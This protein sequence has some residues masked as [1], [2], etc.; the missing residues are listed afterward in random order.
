MR[1]G[2][3]LNHNPLSHQ[4]WSIDTCKGNNFQEAF[5]QSKGL[6]LSSTLF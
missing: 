2:A 4:T 3:F 5:E 1:Q 6:G